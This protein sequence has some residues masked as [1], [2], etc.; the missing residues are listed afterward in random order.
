MKDGFQSGMTSYGDG[1]GDPEVVGWRFWKERWKK[2]AKRKGS[3]K[4]RRNGRCEEAQSS[5]VSSRG[6]VEKMYVRWIGVVGESGN[7]GG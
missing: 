6:A 7:V 5:V 1:V 4:V 2:S 3:Q